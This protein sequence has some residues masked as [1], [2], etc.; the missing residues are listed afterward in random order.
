MVGSQNLKIKTLDWIQKA[1]NILVKSVSGELSGRGYTS[2]QMESS[3]PNTTISG[4]LSTR[5]FIILIGR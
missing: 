3:I 5:Y 1:L 4:S 2:H